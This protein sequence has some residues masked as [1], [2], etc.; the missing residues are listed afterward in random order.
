[1]SGGSTHVT[2]RAEKDCVLVRRERRRTRTRERGRRRDCATTTRERRE[3]ISE[4]GGKEENEGQHQHHRERRSGLH[5]HTLLGTNEK[6]GRKTDRRMDGRGM[7]G[8]GM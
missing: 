6:T 3:T 8:K 7:E 2:K 5:G 1:M 4:R